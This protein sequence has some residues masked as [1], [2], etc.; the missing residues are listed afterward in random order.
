MLANV[1]TA[2]EDCDS[3]VAEKWLSSLGKNQWNNE[4]ARV[5]EEITKLILHTEFEEAERLA[6]DR[7]S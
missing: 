5:L 1:T 2:C 7:K 4:T 6:K 3:D